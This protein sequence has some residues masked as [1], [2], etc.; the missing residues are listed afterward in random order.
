MPSFLPL[1]LR[2]HLFHKCAI[3]FQFGESGLQFR[4]PRLNLHSHLL[5]HI[6]NSLLC[7]AQALHQLRLFVG[8]E[9]IAK[10]RRKP[11]TQRQSPGQREDKAAAIHSRDIE[12]TSSVE[13]L[14]SF[15]TCSLRSHDDST[16]RTETDT[17]TSA[18]GYTTDTCTTNCARSR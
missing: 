6:K 12:G 5:L 16:S 3:G 13:R 17:T 4:D 9:R 11:E 14:T 15:Q 18:S 10:G 7:R 2:T 1:H 8:Q